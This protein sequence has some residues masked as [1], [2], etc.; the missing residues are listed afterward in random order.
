MRNLER[1]SFWWLLGSNS[2]ISYSKTKGRTST[3]F[4]YQ[5]EKKTSFSK[6]FDYSELTFEVCLLWCRLKPQILWLTKKNSTNDKLC[7]SSYHSRIKTSQHH[8]RTFFNWNK[9]NLE[10]CQIWK[11]FTVH[12]FCCHDDQ[13]SLKRLWS[14]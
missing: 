3:T 6:I 10:A 1:K 7:L 8:V 11:T 12:G 14:Q 2:V 5:A 9:Q 4:S 13:D